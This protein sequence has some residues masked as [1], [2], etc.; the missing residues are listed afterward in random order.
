MEASGIAGSLADLTWCAT[1]NRNDS[2]MVDGDN[3]R[4]QLSLDTFLASGSGIWADGAN[5]RFKLRLSA[6]EDLSL[7]IVNRGAI[8]PLLSTRLVQ[9]N[10]GKLQSSP[11]LSTWTDLPGTRRLHII[12][13]LLSRHFYRQRLGVLGE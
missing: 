1:F 3:V 4:V 6:G 5:Q 13:P 2:N 7:Q 9:S 10:G 11:D 8:S 12:D